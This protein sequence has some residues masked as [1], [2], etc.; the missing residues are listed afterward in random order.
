MLSAQMPS[1]DIRRSFDIPMTCSPDRSPDE[2]P[3]PQSRAS[4]DGAPDDDATDN[5]APDDDT[6]DD[7]QGEMSEPTA[8]PLDEGLS[9]DTVYTEIQALAAVIR[10]PRGPSHHETAAPTDDAASDDAP[11]SSSS[12]P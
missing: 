2:V 6:P 9:K 12:E 10:S 11:S 8:E 4:D 5:D 1:L 7:D 3:Y